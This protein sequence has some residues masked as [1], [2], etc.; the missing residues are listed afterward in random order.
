[1]FFHLVFVSSYSSQ[2]GFLI[3]FLNHLNRISSIEKKQV[4]LII[5]IPT[6]GDLAA[7]YSLYSSSVLK[8][9]LKNYNLYS[10]KINSYLKRLILWLVLFSFYPLLIFNKFVFLWQPRP[11]WVKSIFS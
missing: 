5:Q 1:M 9:Y 6:K 3:S 10:L 11:N 8:N 2:I 7:K 4:I